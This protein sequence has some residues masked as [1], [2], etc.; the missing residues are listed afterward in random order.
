VKQD[1]ERQ[2]ALLLAENERPLPPIPL[3][4]PLRVWLGEH[5]EPITVCAD[6]AALDPNPCLASAEVSFGHPLA[7]YHQERQVVALGPELAASELAALAAAPEID[8]ALKVA[9]E[10]VSGLRFPVRFERPADLIFSS[11]AGDGPDL[12]VEAQAVPGRPLLLR[13]LPGGRVLQA[14]VERADL[15]QFRIASRGAPGKPG[16]RGEKGT[17]GEDGQDG[18]DMRCGPSGLPLPATRGQDGGAGGPGGA[19]G[20]GGTGGAIQVRLTCAEA[21]CAALTETLRAMVRSEGGEGGTGGPGGAG[22]TGGQG[23][24]F[25]HCLDTFRNAMLGRADS[26]KDGAPGRSGPAGSPG[27]AG[28]VTVEV[29]RQ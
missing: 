22:G 5:P 1:L 11:G 4:G 26:G 27:R 21:E 29:V 24:V 2:R 23:G 8:L 20:R 12:T 18:I 7:A 17:D 9:G 25:G 16:R 19:G 14:V 15:A 13:V 3:R 10:P 6:P 28:S